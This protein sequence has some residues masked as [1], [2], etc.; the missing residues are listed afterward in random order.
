MPDELKPRKHK[1][2][3]KDVHSEFYE[4]PK[5]DIERLEAIKESLLEE[6]KKLNIPTVLLM[7]TSNT[8]KGFGLLGFNMCEGLRTADPMHA[9][10]TAVQWMQAN[11]P[12]GARKYAMIMA[13]VKAIMSGNPM[14]ALMAMALCSKDE[15]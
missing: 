7:Q 12:E 15:N 10:C 6:C 1:L 4:L 2:N 11:T 8:E 3:N 5:K 14:A 13:T 9:L